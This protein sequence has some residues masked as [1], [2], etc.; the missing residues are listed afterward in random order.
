M[1]W[2]GARF[3]R[4]DVRREPHL[5]RYIEFVPD[6]GDVGVVAAAADE[7]VSVAWA[8]YSPEPGGYGFVDVR[9][10]ECSVWVASGRRGRGLGRAVMSQLL[11]VLADRGAERV[12]LSVEAGNTT[13]IALYRSLG[14]TPVEG[15]EADGVMVWEPASGVGPGTRSPGSAT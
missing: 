3:T 14:F 5:C 7:V 4:D 13:A 12:S 15:R 9:T 10:P 11:D 6:R 2:C 1:N 8:Q